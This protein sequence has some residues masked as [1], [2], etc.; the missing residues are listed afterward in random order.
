M[1]ES[2]KA[3]GI[4]EGVIAVLKD[5][6]GD[7]ECPRITAAIASLERACELLV[8]HVDKLDK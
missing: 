7:E 8:E 3:L 4:I 6:R 5:E 1:D 2:I